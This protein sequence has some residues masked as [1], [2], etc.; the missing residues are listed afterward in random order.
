M[1]FYERLM[2]YCKTPHACSV[3]IYRPAAMN[4]FK[5]KKVKKSKRKHDKKSKKG[6]K[7]RRS[8]SSS[9]DSSTSSSS[10]S[11]TTSSDEK[12]KKRKKKHKKD[13]KRKKLKVE[14]KAEKVKEVEVVGESSQ[15]QNE[16]DFGIPINL[17]DFRRG[18]PE[19]K[20]EYEKRQSIIRRVVDEETGRTRLIR[21]D[22]E[23]IE[24][25][26]TKERH[27]KINKNAT[28]TDAQNFEK[29]SIR[30]ARKK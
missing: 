17:M 5:S 29:N 15:A 4:S 10:T 23:I 30:R 2:H 14:E 13:H 21:G 8:S 6:K 19:T 24:E 3:E 12:H 7:R 1:N 9:S 11:S 20:E 18:A 22:G 27:I 26:V 25:M 16:E 28:K